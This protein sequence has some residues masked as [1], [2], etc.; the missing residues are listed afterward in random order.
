MTLSNEKHEVWSIRMAFK[1]LLTTL[2][3]PTPPPL[4]ALH[5][6]L[7]EPRAAAG[8]FSEYITLPHPDAATLPA[9][10]ST[11]LSNS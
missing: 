11:L 4:A 1:A 9:F 7:Q 3:I 5:L 6:T 10:S 8:G 2:A